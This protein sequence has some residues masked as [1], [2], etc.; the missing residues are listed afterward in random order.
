M[1]TTES[2]SD[3]VGGEILSSIN[4][5]LGGSHRAKQW[6]EIGVIGHS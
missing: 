4:K 3:G 2:L 1:K 5:S 6:W